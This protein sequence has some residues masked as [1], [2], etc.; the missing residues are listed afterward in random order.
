MLY[1]SHL[2]IFW[3]LNDWHNYRNII[4]K[5]TKIKLLPKAKKFFNIFW[6]AGYIKNKFFVY[7]FQFD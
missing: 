6:L 2:H 4:L 5:A 3:C 7:L 1:Q